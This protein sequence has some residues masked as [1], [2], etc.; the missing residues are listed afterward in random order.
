M[1]Y[2]PITWHTSCFDIAEFVIVGS[3]LEMIPKA[4]VLMRPT[5]PLQQAW[6]THDAVSMAAAHAV[7]VFARRDPYS[8]IDSRYNKHDM[9]TYT[10]HQIHTGADHHHT[11]E[12]L[13]MAHTVLYQMK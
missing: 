7:Q 13:L 2:D 3:A 5:L 6:V 9:H 8:T 4:R 12:E 11:Y 1:F 10:M